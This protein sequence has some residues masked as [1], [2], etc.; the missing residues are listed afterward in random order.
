MSCLSLVIATNPYFDI[1]SLE[2]SLNERIVGVGWEQKVL[3]T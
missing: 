1:V 2:K 3:V